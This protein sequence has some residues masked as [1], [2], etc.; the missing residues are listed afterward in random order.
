MSG[1]GAAGA[2]VAPVIEGW[3]HIRTGKVRDL[4]SNDEG[5]ILLEAM[6]EIECYKH[7]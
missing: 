5:E 2:P 7:N 3:T 6:K 1:F 4:Y